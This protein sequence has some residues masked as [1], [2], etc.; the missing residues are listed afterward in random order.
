[1]FTSERLFAEVGYGLRLHMLAFGLSQY[2]LAL[3]L[4]VPL[5]PDDRTYEVEQ[6]DGT[7]AKATRARF[8]IVFGITQTY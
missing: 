4:A 6:A 3:D 2:L 1:M 7:T 8:K 5:W